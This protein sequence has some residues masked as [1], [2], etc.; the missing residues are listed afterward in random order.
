MKVEIE[1]IKKSQS[2]KSENE[3]FKNHRGKP[4]WTEE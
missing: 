1:S 2:G 3:K 4:H